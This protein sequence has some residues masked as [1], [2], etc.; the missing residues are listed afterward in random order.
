[1]GRNFVFR[2]CSLV[3]RGRTVSS[4]SVLGYS[5]PPLVSCRSA[6]FSSASPS[7]SSVHFNIPKPSIF[8]YS[9]FHPFSSAA[10]DSPSNIVLIKT[11]EELNDAYNKVEADSLPAIFYFTAAWCGPCKMIA[12]IIKKWSEEFPHVTTFKIDIDEAGLQ[13]V[14]GKLG[15]TVV[16]TLHFFHN[17]KKESEVVGA[18]IGSLNTTAERLFK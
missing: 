2:V 11:E 1:M 3:R 6:S 18:D 13:G 12:P 17:G 15:I 14:L 9:N 7:R 4:S 8:H 16:P 10:S 5:P